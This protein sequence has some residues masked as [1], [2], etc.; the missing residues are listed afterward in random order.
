MDKYASKYMGG[1]S[2]GGSQGGGYQQYMQKYADKYMNGGSQGGGGFDYHQYMDKY[3]G[4]YMN[5]GA[6]HDDASRADQLTELAA[7]PKS[8]NN[9]QYMNKYAGQYTGGQ[10]GD[11]KK[12]YEKYQQEY[13]SKYPTK[14]QYEHGL[15][16]KNCTTLE[17]LKQWRAQKVA[18]IDNYVPGG[19][20]KYASKDIDEE[21]D[22]NA[23]RI[24]NMT[25][26]ATSDAATSLLQTPDQTSD[27][28]SD[29]KAPVALQA[30]APTRSWSSVLVPFLVVGG[31]GN[32][33]VAF[34]VNYRRRQEAEEEIPYLYAD[35]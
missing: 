6:K 30:L 25:D 16:A 10:G 18:E 29:A 20:Q 24:K 11:Y 31:L 9:Q 23:A 3:A 22:K 21:F 33:A 13:Q 27:P 26:A 14:D 5:G 7:D 17:E 1:G 15:I 4:K 34:I 12:Y 28:A 2:Q 19:Y 35:A 32:L 8:N